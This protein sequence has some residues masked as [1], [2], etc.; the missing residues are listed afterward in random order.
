MIRLQPRQSR[1]L[2]LLPL[3]ILQAWLLGIPC[4]VPLR[5]QEPEED[6]PPPLTSST[7]RIRPTPK[8]APTRSNPE[9]SRPTDKP[10][11]FD[12]PVVQ[13]F[14]RFVVFFIGIQVVLA[15]AL[16]YFNSYSKKASTSQGR[17]ASQILEEAYRQASGPP[18]SPPNTNGQPPDPPSAIAPENPTPSDGP[19]PV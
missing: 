5:A 16:Y 19:K 14:L 2:F 9:S 10:G 6:S 8:T 1:P 7:P 15:I 13:L 12:D 3:L 18:A 11:R 4:L 17:S